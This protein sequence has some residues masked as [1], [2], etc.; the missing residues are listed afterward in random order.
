MSSTLEYLCYNAYWPK[1]GHI[2]VI[3]CIPC[4]IFVF[5]DTVYKALIP[6]EECTIWEWCNQYFLYST[7]QSGHQMLHNFTN[8]N[9]CYKV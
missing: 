7:H 6:K 5:A 9:E 4:L 2:G 8:E 1:L 3:F